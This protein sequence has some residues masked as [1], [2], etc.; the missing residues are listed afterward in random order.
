M[1][2]GKERLPFLTK[3]IYGSGDLGFSITSTIIGFLFAMYL[4]D[5]V[6]LDPGLAAAAVFVGRTCDYINDPLMGHISDRMRTRWGRRRPFLLFGFVPFALTFVLLW[7]IPPIASQIGLAIYYAIAYVIFD[8]AATFAYMPYFALTPELTLDYDERTSLTSYRMLF[9][10][11]GSLFAFVLA[12]MVTGETEPQNSSRFLLM[13]AI[14]ATA[15]ALPLL[16]VF[17]GTRERSEFQ[18]QVRPTVK[19]SLQA[20]LRNR[21]FRFAVVIYLLTWT[22]VAIVQ[23]VLLF[24][25]KHRIG[26]AADERDL[27]TGTIFVV[28]LFA[29]PLWTWASRR[30]DKRL[31]YIAGVAFW[32]AVQIVLVVVSPGWGM[33]VFLVLAG[34]AGIGVAAAHVLPW[35]IIPDAVEWDQLVTGQRHEGMFYSLITLAEKVA[36]SIAIPLSLLVLKLTGY[37]ADL[38]AQPD[39]A[40]LGIQVLMGPVPAVLLC[41][42]ILFALFY[43]LGRERHAQIRAELAARRSGGP[44]ADD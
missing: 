2:D 35:A 3:L 26:L 5:V 42:G 24:F 22:S 34:L 21:P 11:L 43:P 37:S 29:L 9:S 25:L 7:W 41:A 44:H 14:F 19:Q 4:T 1:A 28:A 18:A 36:S 32:A 8:T 30:W 17:L 10:I 31:S 13:A 23:A 38:A 15:S 16:L 20:A 27:V 33:T 12:P 39:S 40:V 6:R